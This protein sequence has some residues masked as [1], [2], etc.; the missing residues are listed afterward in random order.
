[1]TSGGRSEVS[2]N[3]KTIAKITEGAKLSHGPE[4]VVPATTKVQKERIEVHKKSLL[5]A[6][7][8][9]EKFIDQF[10]FLYFLSE[11][12][13]SQEYVIWCKISY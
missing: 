10:S 2:R 13:K 9:R 7:I 4:K 5:L 8:S 6:A 12:Q 11:C 1:M 3:A